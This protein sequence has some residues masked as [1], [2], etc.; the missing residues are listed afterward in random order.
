M[1]RTP[2]CPFCACCNV[3][4]GKYEGGPRIKF[5]CGTTLRVRTGLILSKCLDLYIH[6]DWAPRY[7]AVPLHCPRCHAY[8][9]PH[10]T[11]TFLCWAHW[12]P[13][14]HLTGCDTRLTHKPPLL[15]HTETV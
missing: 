7:G 13:G 4:G 8:R 6:K 1:I 5:C 15:Q 14:N 9:R 3:K 2:T 10:Y 12:V 11:N